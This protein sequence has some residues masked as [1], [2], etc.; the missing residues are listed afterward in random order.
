[1]QNQESTYSRNIM[2]LTS[3]VTVCND[4]LLNIV[5]V[6]GISFTNTEPGLWLLGFVLG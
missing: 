1:M 5:C 3:L 2:G 4:Y 6:C